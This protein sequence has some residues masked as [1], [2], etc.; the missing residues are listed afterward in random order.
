MFY[1][2][3]I[4]SLIK[5]FNTDPAAGLTNVEVNK[6][7]ALYGP[8]LLPV[9]KKPPVITKFLDQF[10]DVLVLILLA[11]TIISFLLGDTLD[12]L[13]IAAIV[14]LNASIGFIQ[15]VQ[16][17]RTLE[18]LKEKE[19]QFALVLRGGQ[20]EKI[21]AQT[22]VK[23]D[24]LILEEGEKIPAD[25]RAI[26]AIS[27]RIDESI[28]TG[29]SMP[30]SKNPESIKKNVP[31][32]DRTNMLY[33]DT[34]ILAGRGK[35]IVVAT[36]KDTEIGQIAAFLEEAKT[37]KTPLAL[38][39]D[40]VGHMLTGIIGFIAVLIFILNTLARVPLV[41]SL[42]I[43]ISLAVAAIPEGLPTIVTIVLSIGVKR[44]AQK[45]TLVKKL[46][47][48]ETL[49]A[50][51]V[52]A[53]DKTGT[54]TQ[55]KINTVRISLADGKDFF[56]EGEGYIPSGTFFDNKKK[57]IDPSKIPALELVLRAGVL[58]SNAT[59]KGGVNSTETEVIGDTTEAALL[60]AAQRA[61]LDIDEIRQAEQRL[62]EVPFS[63]ER[64]MMSVIVKVN[65]TG[66]HLLYS[67]GAPEVIIERC[68]LKEVEKKQLLAK[69]KIMAQKGLRSLAIAQ[70]RL[71]KEE[72]KKALE[73]DFL[74]ESNFIFMGLTFM[75]DPLRAEVK[76]AIR[77][78]KLA[79]IATIMITGDHR[80]TAKAIAIE[81]GIIGESG[82]VLTE[83]DIENLT[84]SQLA[85]IIRKGTAVFARISPMGKLRIVEA[86]KSIPGTLVAVT[87]D[88][89]NDT[90]ALSAAHIGVAMGQTGADLAREVAGIV[91][92]DDNYA[93]IV[94]AIREGRIIFANLV[95][96]IRYLI[97][98]NVSEVLVI[99]AAVCLSTPLPL[100][101]IQILWVNLITD[102]APALALGL[103]SP[104][105]DV[106]KKPPRDQSEGILHKKRWTY[107]T[108]EGVIIGV[109]VFLLFIYAMS[110]YP[111]NIAQ[112][113][114]FCTLSFAQLVHAYNNRSTR[115]SIFKIGFFSNK[116]LVMATISSVA[117]QILVTQTYWGNLVFKT[118]KLGYQNWTI[119]ILVSLI[120]LLISE[121][122]KYSRAV[123]LLP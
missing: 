37:P 23:G 81:A 96:F 24:I 27:L 22:I 58:A 83:E 7:L 118:V 11:A 73:K 35:A 101:P 42:L 56:I 31:L 19:I 41:E 92:T 47:A 75:Q 70:R 44:L 18:A 57:I 87:G 115:K 33:K 59:V 14:L 84:T 104:E 88:G 51:K 105:F 54:L 43:S 26:E 36:G 107:M 20:V 119:I 121:I 63:A 89:V 21:P 79:G 61:N 106:M 91:I 72:V 78:A 38:E 117:L 69:L 95:K 90:P 109:S 123:H 32:A 5:E 74:E 114:A 62:Y 8:N 116:Y 71:T 45:K 6:R 17:E 122:K 52:I 80:E 13:A 66:D 68:N 120:P 65:D 82:Q 97:S 113:M 28:L 112:T 77:E 30:V 1:Q 76:E 55:N 110:S 67:K 50:V 85:Q 108:I 16:A 4:S 111:L 29:E 99:A 3:S 98:C 15:A 34:K 2:Q 48:V 53:T 60:I 40:K 64:K 86:I 100:F 46:L 49:G 12:A 39:L 10:K 102:G 103:D 94:D 25:A 93:T 9:K